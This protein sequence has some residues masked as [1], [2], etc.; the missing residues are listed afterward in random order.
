MLRTTRL[1]GVEKTRFTCTCMTKSLQ[2]KLSHLQLCCLYLSLKSGIAFMFLWLETLKIFCCWIDPNC[3][4]LIIAFCRNLQKKVGALRRGRKSRLT[5][6]LSI[7]DPAEVD[8]KCWCTFWNNFSAVTIP[9]IAC[10]AFL[11]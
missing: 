6:S 9:C 4:F 3:Y 5:I 11:E 10:V 8:S 1:K 7:I 2:S